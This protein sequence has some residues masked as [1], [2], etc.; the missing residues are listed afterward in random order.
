MRYINL[1][2][3]YIFLLLLIIAPVA[4]LAQGEMYARKVIRILCDSSMHGRGYVQKGDSLAAAWISEEFRKTGL[5]AFNDNYYQEFTLS[6]N[7]FPDTLWFKADG[8]TLIPGVEYLIAPGSPSVKGEFKVEYFDQDLLLEPSRIIPFVAKA[9]NRFVVIERTSDAIAGD[10]LNKVVQGLIEWLRKDTLIQI[11]GIIEI[12][13]G[14]LTW[15]V[16][17]SLDA[18]P[19]LIVGKDVFK[20]RISTINIHI[21]NQ[22]HKA[23]RTRNVMGYISGKNPVDS[24]LVISAH[25]DHLG[26]MGS[27]L[28]F[29]GANDNASGVAMM[30]DLAHRLV[31]E[32]ESNY[33]LVFIAFAGE[34]AGLEGSRFFVNNS[35][36]SLDKIK[37]LINLD[38][39]GTGDEGITVVNGTIYNHEFNRLISINSA[40]NFMPTIKARGEAC[41]SDHCYFFKNGVPCFFIYTMGGIQAYHDIHDRVETLPLTGYD[42]LFQLLIRF[43]GQ[44]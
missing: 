39:V 11:A 2:I 3:K 16:R 30:L 5:K 37:F 29:P 19:Y 44:F 15:S 41:N 12:S 9:R 22:F 26:R 31:E 8:R 43:I 1:N 13:Q 42:G 33:V 18:R 17:N 24:I 32:P 27:E 21:K 25:Y 6:V 36:F 23:Y 34:E 7:S 40:H 38:L 14:K 10:S 4:A 20:K 35:P 28:Y